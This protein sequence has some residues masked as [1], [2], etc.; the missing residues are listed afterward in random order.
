MPTV[1]YRHETPQN[2]RIAK[3]FPDTWELPK[4]LDDLEKWLLSEG[5]RLP[6][7][8]YVADVGYAPRSGAFGGGGGLT[9]VAMEAMCSIGMELF[10]SEYPPDEEDG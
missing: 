9:L 2:Q 6:K 3:L 5:V 7:A 8:S 10:L 1:I 4:Q